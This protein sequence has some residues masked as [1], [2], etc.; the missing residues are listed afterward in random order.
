MYNIYIEYFNIFNIV[1][2]QIKYIAI[3]VRTKSWYK[4]DKT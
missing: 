4:L 1:L 2:F 3:F